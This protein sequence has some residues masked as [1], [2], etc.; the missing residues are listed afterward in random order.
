MKGARETY[1]S[2]D[3]TRPLKSHI[4][5]NDPESA[6]EKLILVEKDIDNINLSI[7]RYQEIKTHDDQDM[8]IK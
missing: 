6:C 7:M 1:F 5:H 4:T 3:F 8:D 2:N